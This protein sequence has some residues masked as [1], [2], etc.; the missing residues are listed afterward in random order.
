MSYNKA[1]K[2]YVIG[3]GPSALRHRRRKEIDRAD[4]VVRMNNFKTDG[5]ERWVGSKTDI[6]FTCRLNEYLET[7]DQFPQ[8][9]LCLL[10]NPLD[11]VTIPDKL[12]QAPNV[13]EVID[14]PEVMELTARLNLRE[15]CYPSTGL[16]CVLKMLRRF[17][18][19]NLMGFD[20]FRDGNQHYFTPG[21]RLD[22][23]RHDG[24]GERRI[25]VELQDLGLVTL[26]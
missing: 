6:L 24:P 17:G 23:P 9:V 26:L 11:G 15:D 22:P 7:L 4:V 20:N 13:V 3:N 10:M 12:I 25:L 16:L 8:V 2:I 21:N 1:Q 19:L 14:W 18:H 5:F